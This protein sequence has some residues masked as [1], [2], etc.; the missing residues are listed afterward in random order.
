MKKLMMLVVVCALA[1]A[2]LPLSAMAAEF[3][4]A[5]PAFS[6]TYPDDYKPQPLSAGM[7]L[8]VKP[9]SGLP[10]LQITVSDKGDVAL[11]DY[12]E[13]GTKPALQKL[14]SDVEIL[15]NK[16]AKTKDGSPAYRAEI[17]WMYGGSTLLTTL[18]F[19]TE[20]EGKFIGV[21]VTTMGDLA[22]P[23]EISKSLNLK[24]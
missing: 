6:I 10:V 1:L 13:K 14:G 4:N 23:D 22:K 16:E 3:K 5:A 9:A 20:K 15:S 12:A 7:V 2:F 21:S 24:P 8:N 11:K 18:V 19:V 17:E